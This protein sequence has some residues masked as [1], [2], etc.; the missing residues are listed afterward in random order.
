MKRGVLS[1]TITLA[2]F[3]VSLNNSFAEDYPDFKDT[4]DWLKRVELSAQWETDQHTIFYFQTIQPLYQSIDK[5]DTIFIQPRVSLQADDLTYNL[6]VGYRKLASENLLWGMNLFGDYQDL[7]GHGRLGIGL[8]ALG[9]ILEARFNSYFGITTKRV[10]E[11]NSSSTTYERVADGLDFELGTPLPYLPWL[12][13][14]SS[15]FWYDFD[16]FKDKYGWR[17]RL[18]ARISDAMRLE[19]YT[20]DDNKGEQEYG[21]RLRFT[22]AI[23][24]LSDFKEALILTSE[25]FPK[26]DLTE[27]TLI[28]VERNFDIV[29]EK[30]VESASMTIEIGRGD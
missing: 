3:L 23:D 12:K 20:W 15:G 18:E 10:V 4:P 1:I 27:Q 6:G 24:T 14:Y 21:G 17:A 8:E 22:L 5:V 11:E 19:L 30:W 2:C 26:K 7:Y 28:P 29:V 13:I 25:P 9:Q 16:K